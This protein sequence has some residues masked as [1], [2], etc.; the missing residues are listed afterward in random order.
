MSV[1]TDITAM[2]RHEEQLIEMRKTADRHVADLRRSRQTL[3]Y[4]AQQLAELAEKYSN[5]K[6]AAERPTRRSRIFSPT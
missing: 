3:E 2:K 4:Q 5:K 6:R 1:G